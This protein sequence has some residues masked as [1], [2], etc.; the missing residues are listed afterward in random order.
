MFV[1]ISIH[2]DLK[3]IDP[4]DNDLSLGTPGFHPK[5]Y[6]LSMGTPG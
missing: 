4:K 5:D 6:D 2:R 3:A 1:C